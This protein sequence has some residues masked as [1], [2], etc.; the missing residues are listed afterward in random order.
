MA[1]VVKRAGK[2]SQKANTGSAAVPKPGEAS[3]PGAV[4]LALMFAAGA[5]AV[6]V[7]FAKGGSGGG[8]LGAR[9]IAR[10]DDVQGGPWFHRK[11]P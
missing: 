11:E 9:L 6:A 7:W 3:G 8:A 1:R 2:G 10:G 5:V 4:G